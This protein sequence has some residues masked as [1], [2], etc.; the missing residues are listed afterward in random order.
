MITFI[1]FLV[2]IIAALVIT[3]VGGAYLLPEEAGFSRTATINAP[4][5]KVFELVS[6]FDRF[7]DWSPWAEL[8]PAMTITR[9]GPPQGVGA[10]YAWASNDP[11]VGKGSMTI[12]ESAPPASLKIALDFGE[13]GKSESAW[14]IEPEGTGT[15]ATWSFH[16]G[17][18]G[19]MNRWFGLLMERF[20]GP[21]Y[22]KGLAKLKALAEKE[23][24]G[25]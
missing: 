18:D 13:M 16:M 21:D 10:Q 6:N 19:V 2:G 7:E 25:G 20:A 9:S 23:N 24:Q 17:L 3:I 8:D 14:V 22:E 1:K 15:R 12:T 5:E 4:P 11:G